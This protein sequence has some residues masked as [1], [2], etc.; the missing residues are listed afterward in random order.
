MR[1]NTNSLFDYTY[2]G[3][4]FPSIYLYNTYPM[5]SNKSNHLVNENKN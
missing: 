4:L 1:E 2:G 3:Q 5:I